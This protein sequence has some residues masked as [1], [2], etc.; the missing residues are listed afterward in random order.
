MSLCL[1][2]LVIKENFLN[3]IRDTCK[4]YTANI[5]ND[6]ISI[7]FLLRERTR[8]GLL[9]GLPSKTRQEVFIISIKHC[10]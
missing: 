9:E 4:K 3:L 2:K 7:A 5:T 1:N 10:I 6:E 8:Q